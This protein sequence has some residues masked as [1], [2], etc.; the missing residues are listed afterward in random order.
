MCRKLSIVFTREDNLYYYHNTLL[1]SKILTLYNIEEHREGNT[2]TLNNTKEQTFFQLQLQE[3]SCSIA[4]FAVSRS[5]SRK[6]SQWPSQVMKNSV[7]S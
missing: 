6:I 2:Y 3:A 1:N 5:S 7:S 4:F